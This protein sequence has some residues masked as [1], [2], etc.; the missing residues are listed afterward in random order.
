VIVFGILGAL[1]IALIAGARSA[2]DYAK[3]LSYAR[4]LAQLNPND[5]QVKML[6]SD[7]EKQANH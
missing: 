5:P 7:L 4:E 6:V 3:A 2:G 1:A